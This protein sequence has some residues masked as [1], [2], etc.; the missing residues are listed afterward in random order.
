MLLHVALQE[1]FTGE[2]V[3][4]TAGQR[5]LFRKSDVK[6][7]TQIGLADSFQ[8]SIDESRAT[9]VVSL[10]DRNLS[11]S[12]EVD[13]TRDAHLGVSVTP[14]NEIQFSVQRTPFGYV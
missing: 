6:T 1:G 12:V 14:A 7:R 3:V 2:P 11:R 4:V 10:P 13:L 5:E 9:V 8:A